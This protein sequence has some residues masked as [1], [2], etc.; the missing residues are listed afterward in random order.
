MTDSNSDIPYFI[1]DK[2]QIP[3]VF[4]PYTLDGVECFADLG[5]DP[6]IGKAFYDKMRAGALPITSLLPTPVY[7]DYF[8]PILKEQDLLFIAFSSQLSNT[9]LNIYE[10][11]EE[12]LKKYPERKFRVVD[13]MS[14]SAAETLLVLRAHEMYAAGKTMDEI[15]DWVEENRFRAHAIITVD[16]LK[17]L[18]RGGRIS[19]TAAA[20]G[21]MLDL[22]PVL[23]IGKNGKIVPSEKVQGR[24]KALRVLADR[25]AELIENPEDQT[26]IIINAD[27]QEDA[28]RLQ[29]LIK[30]KVPGI[31]D[32]LIIPVGPVIGTHCGPGTVASCFLGK[33]R[34]L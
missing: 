12:L 21:T 18:K 9:I 25:T 5:R 10:A 23:A 1:V 3:V 24:K 29:D 22:R 14:I 26:L 31:R 20:L 8:E 16:D 28:E 17:Y 6:S 27:A 32:I 11:R 33:E 7:I 30:A 19:G 15:G 13:T 4:M 2:H 34:P